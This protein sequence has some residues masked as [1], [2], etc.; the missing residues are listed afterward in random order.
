MDNKGLNKGKFKI[1]YVIEVGKVID[2][3]KTAPK[4]PKSSQKRTL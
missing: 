1:K 4:N 2:Y 3:G